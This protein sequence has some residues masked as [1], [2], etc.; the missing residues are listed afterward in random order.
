MVDNDIDMDIDEI[1]KLI[2]KNNILRSSIHSLGKKGIG[3]YDL[4]IEIEINQKRIEDIIQLY[5]KYEIF[6][7]KH[8]NS[9][10]N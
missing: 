9:M 3:T 2:F 5:K 6:Y 10:E 1:Q 4:K 7:K 8:H